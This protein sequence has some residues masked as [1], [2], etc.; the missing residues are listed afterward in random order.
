M[1]GFA[2]LL[3]IHFANLISEDPT[4]FKKVVLH[5][6]RRELPPGRGRPCDDAVTRA[7][8]LLATG[9][10][11]QKIYPSCIPDFKYLDPASR[12]VAQSRLRCAVRSRRNARK[13]RR[14]VLNHSAEF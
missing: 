4:E 7:S 9:K 2:S 6:V 1:C 3:K 8:D 13:R 10:P 11:W 12:Q 5:L 14:V